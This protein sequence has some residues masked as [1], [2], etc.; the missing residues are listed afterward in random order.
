MISLE[1]KE[2]RDNTGRRRI[3]PQAKSFK[4]DKSLCTCTYGR[5]GA[6]VPLGCTAQRGRPSEVIAGLTAIEHFLPRG[7]FVPVT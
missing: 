5:C 4:G 7:K 6:P 3:K 1:K 2:N